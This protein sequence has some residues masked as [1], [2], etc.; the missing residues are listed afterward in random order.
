[1]LARAERLRHQVPN[2][3]LCPQ[4]LRRQLKALGAEHDDRQAGRL[5]SVSNSLRQPQAAQP[6]HL[7][8]GHHDVRSFGLN[9]LP[10]FLPIVSADHFVSGPLELEF[11]GAQDMQLVVAEQN[12]FSRHGSTVLCHLSVLNGGSNPKSKIQNR[13]SP[14]ALSC[15]SP[16]RLTRNVLPCP[17]SLLTSI[18]PLCTSSTMCLTSAR[19]SPVP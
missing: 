17:S 7:A 5:G 2:A 3:V 8:I 13:K 12:A 9:L 10:A 15:A 4:L 19:P 11:R 6:R 1:Q 14:Y 18:R 16:G